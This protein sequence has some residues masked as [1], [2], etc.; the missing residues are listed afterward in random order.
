[1]PSVHRDGRDRN[2]HSGLLPV[3]GHPDD[4]VSSANGVHA[5]TIAG[6]P[7]LES[8]TLQEIWWPIERSGRDH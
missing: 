8:T 3:G 4:F 2:A 7:Q 1:M 6:D 5:G